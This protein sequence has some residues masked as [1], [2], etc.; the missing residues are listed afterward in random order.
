MVPRVPT[1]PANYK[2]ILD[3]FC[4]LIQVARA[5]NRSQ[6]R[7]MLTAKG[8]YCLKALVCLATLPAGAMMQGVK[9]AEMSNI[10]TE[11]LHAILGDLRRSGVVVSKKGPGGGYMLAR[12]PYNIRIGEVIR[13]MDG[14]LALLACASRT[15]FHPCHDCRDVETC[16]IRLMMTRVR[17]ATSDILD[18]VSVADLAASRSE[19]ARRR[20]KQPPPS[21]LK[22][23]HKLRKA[24]IREAAS[25]QP[26]PD[27]RRARS[28]L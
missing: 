3:Q 12:A 17:D 8:K 19:S 25:T 7:K 4:Q 28:S 16:T 21:K 15:A 27:T 26:R 10:P 11:F 24:P 13:I 22:H 2:I 5:K 9:I 18:R 14:P 6:S 1:L 23:A 20:V